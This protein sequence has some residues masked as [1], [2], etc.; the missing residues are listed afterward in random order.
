MTIETFLIN[1]VC[2]DGTFGC[3]RTNMDSSNSS[4]PNHCLTL[5]VI[6]HSAVLLMQY[7]SPGEKETRVCVLYEYNKTEKAEKPI[8]KY[9]AEY[10]NIFLCLVCVVVAAIIPT[11]ETRERLVFRYISSDEQLI[12]S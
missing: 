12:K 3:G 4:N 10:F 8:W 1:E 7:L 2:L 11:S 6:R 5:M 9:A